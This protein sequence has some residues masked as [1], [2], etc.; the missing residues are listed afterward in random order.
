MNAQTNGDAALGPARTIGFIGAGHM[1]E[2][3]VERLLAAGH[4]VRLYARRP[5][6]RNRFRSFGAECV[7]QVRDIAACEVVISCLYSDSQV[8]EVLPEVVS[9]M[10]ARSVLVSHTTGSP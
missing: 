10:D 4:R 5:E 7:E 1:G 9:G 6:V 2:P 8:L 3:M